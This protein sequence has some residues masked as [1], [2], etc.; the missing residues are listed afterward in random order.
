MSLSLDPQLEALLDQAL[1]LL[2]EALPVWLNTLPPEQAR[3][4]EAL[5]ALERRPGPLDHGPER[6]AAEACAL[7]DNEPPPVARFGVYAVTGLIGSG[8]MATVWQA[9]RDDGVVD[10]T[11][12]VKCLKSGLATPELRGRFLREQ[13]ILA[14]LV[15]PNIAQLYDAGVS[16]E[17]LPYIVME[18]IDGEPI[19]RYCDRH[20]LGLRARLELFRQVLAAVAHAQQHLIVHRDLKPANVLVDG[21]G[22]PKLLD[23]GIA[24]L[25]D[26]ESSSQQTQVRALTP[27][28]AAPE[29]LRGEAVS[30]AT[31][32][33]AL[34]IV[35]H[36]LLTGCRPPLRADGG[37]T[38]PAS[39]LVLRATAGE[40][41]PVT[42]ANERGFAKQQRWAQALRGDLDLMLARAL[43]PEPA[44]RYAGAAEFDADIARHL[45]RLPVLARPDSAGYR[46]RRFLQRNWLPVSALLAM[47]LALAAGAV[48]AL[49]QAQ[50]ARQQAARATQALADTERALARAD[51]LHEFLIG[52]FQASEPDRPRD[53]LPSTEQLLELGA[54][55]ALDP[56][57]AEAPE[58]YAMLLTIGRIYGTQNRPEQARPLLDAA[59]ALAREH[60]QHRPDD[61]ALVLWQLARLVLEGGDLDSA[62][63]MLREAQEAVAGDPAHW[64]TYVKVRAEQAYVE[65]RLGRHADAIALN[66]PLLERL[67]REQP[68]DDHLLLL[69]MTPL[70]GAHEALGELQV[71]AA[72]GS[73]ILA[74]VER[75]SGPDSVTY[76]VQLANG[77]A[78]QHNLGRF[79]VAEARARQALALYDRIYG[80]ERAHVPRA[81]ARNQ[82]AWTLLFAGRFD[83]ALAEMDASTAERAEAT[84]IDYDTYA[85]R[86][87]HRGVLLTRMRRWPEAELDLRRAQTLFV[88]PNE[89]DR[90]WLI[91]L[92]SHL[93]IALCMQ[94]RTSDGMAV[95]AQL[96]GR[97]GNW[98]GDRPMR[99]AFVHE[100][101]ARCGFHAGDLAR[102]LDDVDEALALDAVY[103]GRLV[104]E[105]DRRLLRAEIVLAMGRRDEAGDEL[106]RAWQ[107]F[108]ELGM[109]GHPLLP[110]IDAM[111]VRI[112]AGSTSN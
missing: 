18:R 98:R 24:K 64:K 17:G 67:R 87:L 44:R 82:L 48:L 103:P 92:D 25:L 19:D 50:Q 110:E 15:H 77:I 37:P 56:D 62:L 45:A 55:R 59:L 96:D 68:P 88:N 35:L 16:A 2:P 73:E 81:F 33:Y 41:V 12:A 84:G 93:A 99:R 7:N 52:L 100:A 30:T 49:W 36:E 65:H 102:A 61:L 80:P 86:F 40:N 94:Q 91:N 47:T 10:R 31:D 4:L 13:R 72:L 38:A 60:R 89:E 11:V 97:S 107:R 39:T 104:P 46:T 106:D 63:A 5:L 111:R 76:A 8:G 105:T 42:A 29:Q 3:Q 57:A 101:R 83:E 23:F 58:R 20:R 9:E 14:R 54:R 74:I 66:Q 22:T 78:P 27:S 70:L 28:Y 71:S 53:Q 43:H 69:V 109:T 34:G 6:L 90:L 95:L 75:S 85:Y 108:V 32:V 21:T 1:A 112:G 26:E 51:R 79:D